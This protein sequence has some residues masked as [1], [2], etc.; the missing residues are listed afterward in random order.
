MNTRDTEAGGDADEQWLAEAQL[1]LALK[2]DAPPE[3]LEE[4]AR[5]VRE[6]V[7]AEGCTARDLFGSPSAHARTVAR[8]SIGE[9][10]RSRLDLRGTTP[11]ERLA[12]SVA[13]LGVIGAF[14]AV[15]HWIADGLWVEFGWAQLAATG[16]VALTALLGGVAIAAWSAGRL[17]G[18]RWFAVG[19]LAT[20]VAGATSG[21]WLPDGVLGTVPAPALAAGCLALGAAAVWC[22]RTAVDRWFVPDLRPGEDERWLRHLTGLLR[23]RHGMTAAEARDRVTEARTH[24]ADSGGTALE[25][26]GSAEVYAMRL[27]DG[28]RR[29]DRK[30]RRSRYGVTALAVLLAV[31]FADELRAPQPSSAWFWFYT[32]ATVFWIGYAARMWHRSLRAGASGRNDG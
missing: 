11:G 27:S 18:T 23:G 22:P 1:R 6:T 31:M 12:G 25:T 3:L 29:E 9:E 5:E 32:V 16:S 24:L 28:P 30:D 10:Y 21:A 13:T 8:E 26:F 17:G 4:M 2:H 7:A 19:A 14:L 15:A 20:V